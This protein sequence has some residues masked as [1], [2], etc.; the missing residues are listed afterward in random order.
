[1][2]IYLFRDFQKK[3]DLVK[4][5]KRKI[6]ERNPDEFY[7]NMVNTE[8]KVNFKSIFFNSIFKVNFIKNRMVFIN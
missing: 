7:F 2:K 4:N 1:M 3:R 5:V 8:I 6:Q